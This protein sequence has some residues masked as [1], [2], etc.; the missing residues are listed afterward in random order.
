MSAGSTHPPQPPRPTRSTARGAL[1]L[2]VAVALTVPA[3]VAAAATPTTRAPATP[4][5][6]TSKAEALR[7]DRVPALKPAWFD[8]S[9]AFGPR[10]ECG[11]VRLPLDYDQ[12]TGPKTEVALLRIKATDAKRRIGSLFLN[13]GGPGGSG[14]GIAA[15]SPDF[16][17]ADV[18]AR[19]DV[20]GMDPRGTNFSDNVRCFKDLG[21]QGNAL[22]GLNVPFPVT[23]AQTKAYVASSKAFGRACSTTG[24][25]LSGSMSTAEVARDMDVL[26]RSLGDSK[27]SYLGF[28]YG[29]YLGN[30]YANL[31][32]DRVRAV[33]I[34]GVLDPLGWAGTTANN[35]R[36]QTTR[37]RSGEGAAAALSEIL[38]LCRKAGPKFCAYAEGGDPERKYA[39]LVRR[40]KA[41]PIQLRDE[42]TGQ[43][44]F[45][46][47]YPVL[48]GFLLGDLYAP[49]A[50]ELIDSDLTFFQELADEQ[51]AGVSA[52]RLAGSPAAKKVLAKVQA[53]RARQQA[54]RQGDLKQ[55]AGLAAVAGRGKT[56]RPG[57]AFPYD[58]SPEAFQSVLCTDGLNPA[59]AADW[60]GYADRADR[61]A[62]G[63]GQL[64]TWASAPCASKTWTVRD[65]DA[66]RGPFTHRTASPVLVVGNFWDPAT[67][68]DGAVQAASLLP[69]SRLLSSDNFGH[70]A[71][72]TSECVTGAVDRYLL[73]TKVP[74]VGTLCNTDFPAFETPLA[75]PGAMLRSAPPS[76]VRGLPPVVPPVP[77][78]LPRR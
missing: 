18:R 72:G 61:S 48:V 14:V 1:C 51:A 22:S 56:A 4:S 57:F 62:P 20:I 75:G 25:P 41:N 5:D 29:T 12:P 8:C 21:A 35:L 13:P 66:Y 2:L 52:V 15:A 16:L 54:A 64:W 42:D 19:F 55:G 78:G 24:K 11:T 69:N 76:A 17:G 49:F 77:G 28:S 40:L 27:L 6:R 9:S 44:F 45:T 32:P 10:A 47:D 68:Y 23:P 37:I 71:Y 38:V 70:T 53:E 58:N 33:V 73:T 59:N 46:I 60:A 74:G 31:F 63:F 65:E 30:V 26:R 36:P 7:V 67:N 34:D 43:V 3:G 50:P 39:D